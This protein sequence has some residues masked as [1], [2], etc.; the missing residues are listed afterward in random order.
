[1]RRQTAILMSALLLSGTAASQP[2][3]RTGPVPSVRAVMQHAQPN[4]RIAAIRALFDR[5]QR[6]MTS[7][8]VDGMSADL[9]PFVDVNIV[10]EEPGRYSANQAASILGRFYLARKPIAFSFT[11]I[12]DTLSLPY[13]TGPISSIRRGNRETAQVYVSLRRIG[14]R[15]RIAQLN[16]Y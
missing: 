3:G 2:P 5:V 9:A 1:M 6:S 8:S 7:G 16:I 12:V 13:A 15:W 10:G 14:S 11:S 4:A